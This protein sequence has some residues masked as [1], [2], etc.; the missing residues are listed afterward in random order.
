MDGYIDCKHYSKHVSEAVL[1]PSQHLQTVVARVTMNSTFPTTPIKSNNRP[2]FLASVFLVI[3][4]VIIFLLFCF[5]NH[6]LHLEARTW[7]HVWRQCDQIRKKVG[8]GSRIS[9]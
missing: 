7:H 2:A 3:V 1:K 5:L 6:F 8:N 9:G 4:V